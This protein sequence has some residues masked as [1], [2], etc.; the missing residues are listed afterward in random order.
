MPSQ[1]REGLFIIGVVLRGLVLY[2][3]IHIY[4]YI[5]ICI[6]IYTSIQAD[7]EGGCDLFAS[8]V[9]VHIF[10]YIHIYIERDR[11]ADT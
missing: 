10:I 7:H 4:I 9:C 6:C 2:M 11:Y 5:Y 3:Y 8:L 1:G